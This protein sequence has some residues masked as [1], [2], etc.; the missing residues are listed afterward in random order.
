MPE[1]DVTALTGQCRGDDRRRIAL[2]QDHV[3]ALIFEDLRNRSQEMGGQLIE[4]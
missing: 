1:G 2:S 3:G 4:R